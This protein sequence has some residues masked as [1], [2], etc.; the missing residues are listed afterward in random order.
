MQTFSRYLVAII[1]ALIL[2]IATAGGARA[3]SRTLAGHYV[4]APG[5]HDVLRAV[6]PQEVEPVDQALPFLIPKWDGRDDAGNVVPLNRLRGVALSIRHRLDVVMRGE[7][8]S[9]HP[10]GL[11][12]AETGTRSFWSRPGM[13]EWG[14]G[15]FN[16]YR[17][18]SQGVG[19]FDGTLD[20]A[21]ASGWTDASLGMSPF[22]FEYLEIGAN[23]DELRRW[24]GPGDVLIYW[25]PRPHAI[26]HGLPGHWRDWSTASVEVLDV[27]PGVQVEVRYVLGSPLVPGPYRVEASLW[28]DAGML[29]AGEAAAL[30][31]PAGEGPQDR[32]LGTWIEY[33]DEAGRWVGIE[34]L[35][36]YQATCGGSS[37]GAVR[38][39]LDGEGV[40]GLW[41]S[42][43]GGVGTPGPVAAWDGLTD[44]AGL[45]GREM[46]QAAGWTA[47]RRSSWS[48]GVM[49]GEIPVI[50]SVTH[51]TLSPESLTPGAVFA[52]DGA[53]RFSG[54]ARAVRVYGL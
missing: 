7:N 18:A 44:W 8:V 17:A 6:G 48:L 38:L 14:G 35:A 40:P 47:L 9:P 12:Q 45:S 21:G 30:I 23:R 13:P 25:S 16:S 3:Q 28:V 42:D 31:L 33:A 10:T 37:H 32:L 46:W 54:R 27:L 52:W 11:W 36:G 49:P 15:S 19:G 20:G 53:W 26:S 41:T 22:A 34:N 50:A 5:P 39:L 1:V 43:T 51:A 29:R 24:V 4:G 2:L